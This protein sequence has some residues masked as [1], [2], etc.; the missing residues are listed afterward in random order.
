MAIKYYNCK[1]PSLKLETS[2]GHM[3]HNSRTP[4]KTASLP[5]LQKGDDSLFQLEILEGHSKDGLL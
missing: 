5:Q 2:H 1:T 3:A 4:L